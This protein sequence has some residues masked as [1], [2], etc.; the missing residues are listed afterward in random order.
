MKNKFL[1]FFLFVFFVFCFFIFYKSVNTDNS[2]K[3]N[4]KLEKEINN[5]IA[6]DFFSGDK[7]ESQELFKNNKFYIVNIWA[8]W[9]RP[10]REEHPKLMEL[11]RSQN[12]KL[13]G[14]NYRDN[15]K[16]AKKFIADH[17][18]PFSLLKLQRLHSDPLTHE[19]EKEGIINKAIELGLESCINCPGCKC[20]VGINLKDEV[21]KPLIKKAFDR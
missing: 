7:I 12:V 10:C 19:S 11:S 13:I 3:P 20:G 6:E 21:I 8:A 4:V 14:I 15:K 17:G 9:C 5:F 16:K 18:N 1:L 2:Y